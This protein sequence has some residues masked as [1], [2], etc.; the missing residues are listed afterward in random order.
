MAQQLTHETLNDKK[1][2]AEEL[3]VEV[4]SKIPENKKDEVLHLVQL[5]GI[6][7]ESTNNATDEKR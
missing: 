5:S 4:L 2:S 7:Y 1:K 6:I 3:I